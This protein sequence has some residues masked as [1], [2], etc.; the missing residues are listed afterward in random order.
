[1][2]LP[3]TSYFILL[4]FEKDHSRLQFDITMNRLMRSAM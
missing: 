4:I 1:M 3:Q 2:Q